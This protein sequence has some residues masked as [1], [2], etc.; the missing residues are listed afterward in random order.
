MFVSG[1]RVWCEVSVTRLSIRVQTRPRRIWV[2]NLQAAG[3]FLW[4]RLLVFGLGGAC[5]RKASVLCAGLGGWSY[6]VLLTCFGS[7]VVINSIVYCLK[8]RWRAEAHTF[9]VSTLEAEVLASLPIPGH[10]GLHSEKNI[11]NIQSCSDSVREG[12][13]KKWDEPGLTKLSKINV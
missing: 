3:A 12:K 6:L 11:V 4:M 2:H 10:S 8:M 7:C 5:A 13:I 9:N 1:V